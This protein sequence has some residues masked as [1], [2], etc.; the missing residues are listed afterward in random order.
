VIIMSAYARDV[1]RGASR[2]YRDSDARRFA[3]QCLIPGEIAERRH[4]DAHRYDVAASGLP[5]SRLRT[6]ATDDERQAP[7]SRLHCMEAAA[8]LGAASTPLVLMLD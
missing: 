3:R 2:P 1:L 7:G 6:V 5:A 8:H 4:L